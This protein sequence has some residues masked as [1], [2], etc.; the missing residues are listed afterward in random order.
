MQQ[1]LFPLER[2]KEAEE[3]LFDAFTQD[4]LLVDVVALKAAIAAF[5]LSSRFKP[6]WIIETWQTADQNDKDLIY[7]I[8]KR[9]HLRADS[10]SESSA[11]GRKAIRTGKSKTH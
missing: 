6:D 8:A 2:A 10:E 9:L 7:L 1:D 5:M 3:R 4:E 11:K